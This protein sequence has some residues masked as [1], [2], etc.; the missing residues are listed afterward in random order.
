MKLKRRQRNDNLSSDQPVRQL[1]FIVGLAWE[2]GREDV[3]AALDGRAESIAGLALFDA[4]GDDA[5]DF[6]PGAGADFLIDAAV[7]QYLDTM[8]E[9]RD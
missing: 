7:S 2:V 5:N 9:Q 8:F 1:V 4:G 6:V 3:A